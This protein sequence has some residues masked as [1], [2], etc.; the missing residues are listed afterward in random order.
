MLLNYQSKFD[1]V[2]GDLK[3][4]LSDISENCPNTDIFLVRISSIIKDYLA[5]FPAQAPLPPP[6]TPPT[7]KKITLKKTP[8]ISGNETF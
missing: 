7:N 3:N 4:D 1:D 2:L 8:Y 6:Q 5:H